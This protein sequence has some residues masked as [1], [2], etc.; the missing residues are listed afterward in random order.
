MTDTLPPAVTLPEGEQELAKRTEDLVR[1]WL[2]KAAAT[3]QDPSAARLAGV[4]RDPKGLAFTVGFVDGVVRPEDLRAAA[5]RLAAIAPDVPRFLPLPLRLA[6]RLGG[7][8]A[9]VLPQV[10]VPVARRALRGMVAHL[11]IDAT[12]RRL[13]P[14]IA[15]I[16]ERGVRLNLNL[17]GEAVLGEHEA[18]RRLEGTRALVKRPDVD[19]V[20]IKVS[21]AVAPH[22]P[23]AFDEAVDDIVER[24]EPLYRDAKAHGTFLNL[25]MEEFKDLDLTIAVFQRLLDE[26]RY[27]DY[28]AGIVLQAY[29]P[30]AL[31][32]MI[33][34]QEWSAL[35][36]ARGGAPIKVRLVKGANLPM[37]RVESSLHD[38]PLA[39]WHTKAETDTNYKRVLDYA[40]TPERV[41]A[42]KLGVAGHNLFDVAHAWLLA[43]DRGVRDG[44]DFEMLLGMATGQAEA[45]RQDVGGL[46]VYTPVVHP[47]EF[48]V[49]IAYLVRRLEEGASQD[50]F[51]SA[52]FELSS[53]PALFERERERFLTSLAALDPHVPESHRRPR[54]IEPRTAD[55]PF[56][57]AVDTDPAVAEHRRWA[58]EVLGAASTSDAGRATLEAGTVT[59][60]VKL[61]ALLEQTRAAGADWGARPAAERAAVLRRAAELLEERRGGLVEV[62]ASEAGKTM[63]QADPEVSEAIDFA[64]YYAE[65]ALELEQVDG[66]RFVPARL[67]VVAPPWNFPVAIP[68]GGVLAALA[69]GSGVVLKPAGPAS[70]C[71]A[72]LAEALWAAGVPRD[73]LAFVQVDEQQL[74][75]E[76]IAD[77][78]VDRVILTGAWET[79]QL[80]RSFR[81]D[82]PLLAETSGKNAMVITPSADLDL[83]VK[84]L[85]Q[86]A[87]GH[88]GQKCSAASLGILV[89]SVATSKRFLNQLVDAVSSLEVGAAWNPATR[90]GP[91]IEPAA[92][93]LLEGLTELGAGERWLLQ[94][95]KLDAEGRLWS[96][97]I[98]TGV[99]PGSA[100]HRTEYFG[101]VLGL[102]IAATLEEAIALENDVAFGLT[103]GL[104]SLEPD[105]IGTWIDGVQAGNL[106]VNRG[107]T[108]AIVGRQPFGGW[109]RSSVGP[110]AK[111]GGPN[112]LVGLGAWEADG[113]ASAPDAPLADAVRRV[114]A[115]GAAD[116]GAFL[117]SAARADQDAWTGEF[118][119]VRELAGL[120]AERNLWRYRPVAATVRLE[121]DGAERD[122]LRVLAAGVRAGGPLRVSTARPLR[123][124][125]GA[126]LARLQIPVSVEGAP[127]LTGR[128]RQ[129]G[130]SAADLLR[131]AGGDPDLAIWGGPVS[132]AGRLELL[133]FVHEQS[134]SITAHRF[135]TPNHL[136]D[137]VI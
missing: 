57:N 84:D 135:G 55:A 122:L 94:P 83:A 53:N 16:R 70:R 27:L 75:R 120:M 88:A 13:G 78:R 58:R 49:A 80:F 5:K 65:R 64:R 20:S 33:R 86:S 110:G 113:L 31:G 107:T 100:F 101:P 126:L 47:R 52:V 79:A 29:L 37:E 22:S 92:G 21:A 18:D 96:P 63:D 111:A 35:R 28:S 7:L 26:P 68:A 3:R 133:P 1:T 43:G 39:T 14:A 17:L 136:T 4:L 117:R 11:I 12:P 8:T 102:M 89:G 71:G 60:A 30:D 99:R 72:V 132:T 109:K 76:L 67:T 73:A 66:A 90:M 40:L 131:A 10:V 93:K 32:A 44:I 45:V 46:L 74:G 119:A 25:D 116:D 125:V 97:G 24:L 41:D 34:L 129:I 98:R 106:Y 108:G 118:G 115:L 6:V 82:L 36:R 123:P 54:S 91:V 114:L 38:W 127:V 2:E 56:R 112:Y 61:D 121:A 48:D 77:P 62:M 23:W 95:K 137:A 59:E 85:V 9:P 134:V 51:M 124:E 42:V 103:A 105:E 128:V 87:F 69:A 130:G 104:Q 81:P 19:Y 50:N 15:R